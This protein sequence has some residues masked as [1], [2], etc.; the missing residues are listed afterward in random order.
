MEDTKQVT[1]KAKGV[2][3]RLIMATAVF[4]IILGLFYLITNE[5]VL[6][7]ET[8]FDEIIFKAFASASSP[9]IFKFMLF[10]TFFGSTKFLLPAYSLIVV[11]FL[12][13]KR[14]TFESLNIAAIGLSSVG[15]LFFL[16]NLFKRHRPLQPLVDVSGYSYPSGHSF[17]A[18]TFSGMLIYLIWQ[19][20]IKKAFKILFSILLFL[21]GCLIAI[22]RVFLHVHYPTDIIAGF[23]LS[24]LWLSVCFYFLN[25][26]YKR[27]R[28]R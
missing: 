17:S 5:V 24:F 23:C 9:A 27:S 26:I 1:E 15:L 21:F 16:K 12:F 6:E 14:K 11:Y 13:L 10:C 7:H 22:S 8:K 18:F 2:S 4:A 28:L 20:N 3:L 25:R 19:S